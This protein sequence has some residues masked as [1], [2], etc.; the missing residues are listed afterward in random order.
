MGI[1]LALAGSQF[2]ICFSPLLLV[3]PPSLL[4]STL[5]S[6]L[7]H[8]PPTLYDV[9]SSLHLVVDVVRLVCVLFCVFFH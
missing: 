4:Q 1:L 3:A 7:P 9:I 5:P 6:F 8:P 2:D